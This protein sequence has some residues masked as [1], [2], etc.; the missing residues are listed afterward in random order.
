MTSLVLLLA[1]M[2]PPSVSWLGRAGRGSPARKLTICGVSGLLVAVITMLLPAIYLTFFVAM[3][4]VIV[5]LV[6]E[7]WRQS[8]AFGFAVVLTLIGSVATLAG[9]LLPMISGAVR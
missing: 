7:T 9:V 3:V 6:P 2:V 8:R 1:L 4:V 5:L